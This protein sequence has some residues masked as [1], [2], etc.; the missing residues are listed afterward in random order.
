MAQRQS[1]D[2]PGQAHN[3]PI[4][5][6]CKIGNMVFSSGIFGRD[7]KTGEIPTEPDEQAE[8]LFNNIRIFMEAAGGSPEH[9]ARVTVYTKD[10]ALRASI[11]KGWN[12]MFPDEHSR[13]ARHTLP[14]EP[15]GGFLFS[16]ELIAVLS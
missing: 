4:P 15:R 2:I 3:A 13:P 9:I 6:G 11:N 8:Q 10:D 1:I 12:K 14:G 5:N 7:A 16:A